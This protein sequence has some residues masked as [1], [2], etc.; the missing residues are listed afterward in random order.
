MNAWL[1]QFSETTQQFQPLRVTHTGVPKQ[2]LS[3]CSDIE[4]IHEGIGVR[5]GIFLQ[6]FTTCIAGFVIGFYRNW[7]LTLVL[8]ALAPVITLTI[9][10]SYLVS[11]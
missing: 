1:V 8:L 3:S 11:P 6:L 9:V 7:R 2:L 10:I 4:K 5:L